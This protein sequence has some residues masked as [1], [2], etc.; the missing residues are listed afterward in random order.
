MCTAVSRVS[1]QKPSDNLQCWSMDTTLSW[2]SVTMCGSWGGTTG[3]MDGKE[4]GL[5]RTTQ[6]RL[7]QTRHKY[8]NVFVKRRGAWASPNQPLV[9]RRTNARE[10][11]LH[12]DT[13]GKGLLTHTRDWVLNAFVKR[14]VHGQTRTLPCYKTRE[15]TSKIYIN[16]QDT[17]VWMPLWKERCMGKPETLPCHK[18]HK[19]ISTN[20]N[21]I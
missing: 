6:G 18:T 7:T 21:N 9:T 15:H 20:D 2:K 13:Q 11:G 8:S 17:E 12:T 10:E 5:T 3:V 16:T 1:A 14:E 19:K 4:I